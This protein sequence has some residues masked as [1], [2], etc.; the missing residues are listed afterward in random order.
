MVRT[1]LTPNREKEKWQIA[2]SGV[3][4][5]SK[6]RIDCAGVEFVVHLGSPQG[7]ARI[8]RAALLSE[9]APQSRDVSE[10]SIAAG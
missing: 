2:A 3:W 1:G 6:Q 7:Q 4:F 5:T 8:C 10:A 9:H